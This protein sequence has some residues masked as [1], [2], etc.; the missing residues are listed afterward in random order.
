MSSSNVFCALKTCFRTCSC[1]F[2]QSLGIWRTMSGSKLAACLLNVSEGINVQVLRRIVEKA[3]TTTEAAAVINVLRDEHY[4]RTVITIAGKVHL[5]GSVEDS[6]LV[7]IISVLPSPYEEV[8]VHS[9]LLR[10]SSSPLSCTWPPSPRFSPTRTCWL[11]FSS[12]P[13]HY[14]LVNI[15]IWT[16]WW[17]DFWHRW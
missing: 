3:V 14:F 16:L 13:V 6:M 17:C 15:E 7:K 5:S 9:F 12:R 10:L 8:R 1:A 11:T 2:I 4:N